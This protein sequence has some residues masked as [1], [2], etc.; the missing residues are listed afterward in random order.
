MEVKSETQSCLALCH[1][2][3]YTVHGI[4]LAKILEWV[5]VPFS[6]ELPDL[7]IEL[8]FPGLQADSLPVELPGK[9]IQSTYQP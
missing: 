5:A 7:G 2:M 8:G 1:P 4:L 6:R 9:P 3:D